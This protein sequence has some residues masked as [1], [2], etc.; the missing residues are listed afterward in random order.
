MLEALKFLLAIALGI[1]A[2]YLLPTRSWSAK[3]VSIV[4]RCTLYTLIV[5]MGMR[6]SSDPLLFQHLGELGLHA[7]IFALAGIAGA[8]LLTMVYQRFYHDRRTAQE[9]NEDE[10]AVQVEQSKPVRMVLVLLACLAVGYCIPYFFFDWGASNW[11]SDKNEMLADILLL[12]MI[13]TSGVGIGQQRGV[14]KL[15]RH[16]G[17]ALLIV[18]LCNIV[19]TLLFSILVGWLLGYTSL[20]SVAA[21]IAMGWY[22]LGGVVM[23]RVSAQLGLLTFL[24]SLLRELLAL[25]FTPLIAKYCGPLAAI[26][27]GGST[28]LD[29]TLPVILQS[30]GMRYSMLAF[31]NGL[32]LSVFVPIALQLVSS[33]MI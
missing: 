3:A 18:P 6:L 17:W 10:A 14:L 23:A 19:G 29:V 11:I 22:T 9:E 26:V 4:Q 27:P 1:T 32:L 2:G 8:V 31:S 25:I 7:L 28:T 12:L 5:L 15:L 20:E 24:I 13:F 21:N 16:S 30:T 33:F